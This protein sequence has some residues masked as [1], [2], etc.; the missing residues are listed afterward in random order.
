MD[1]SLRLVTSLET[2]AEVLAAELEQHGILLSPRDWHLIQEWH[3]NGVPAQL[4][5]EVIQRLRDREPEK[6]RH[7]AYYGPAIEEAR[8]DL[9]EMQVTGM[10]ELPEPC[11]DFDLYAAPGRLCLRCSLPETNHAEPGGAD[12][13][14]AEHL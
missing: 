4:A 3:D 13:E 14:E 1:G 10:R 8:A 2:M 12:G 6:R 11:N 9:A 7:L 5:L